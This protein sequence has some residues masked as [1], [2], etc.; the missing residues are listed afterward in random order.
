MSFRGGRR[1]TRNLKAT[2]KLFSPI[3]S[4]IP[5]SR[6]SLGMTCGGD[7]G[8]A[9]LDLALR[10]RYAARRPFLSNSSI[11]PDT[12]ATT[13]AVNLRKSIESGLRYAA[14]SVEKRRVTNRK[15]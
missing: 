15:M 9:P 7:G 4:E 11:A 3:D 2:N 14:G 10:I 13:I 6:C 12:I 8:S 5:R 1:P